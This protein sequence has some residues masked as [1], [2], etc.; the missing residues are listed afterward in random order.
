LDQ[1]TQRKIYCKNGNI[2]RRDIADEIILVPIRGNIA[3]LQ[4]IFSLDEV[5]DF[6][7]LQLDGQKT[8]GD[9]H[10]SL[11]ATFDVEVDQ[12]AEDLKGFIA[13]L[14]KANLIG[15]VVA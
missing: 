6:I 10:T 14:L 15:E 11:L 2:V 9:I 13:D 1:Q 4:K 8:C 3:D 7:W 5:A 12:A